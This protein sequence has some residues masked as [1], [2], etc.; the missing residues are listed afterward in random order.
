[1]SP[2]ALLPLELDVF[3]SRARGV[4]PPTRLDHYEADPAVLRSV[5]H[6]DFN[7]CRYCGFHSNKYQQAVRLGSLRDLDKLVTACIF[8]QS[9]VHL[10][11]VESARCG[12]LVWLP[13]LSQAKLHEFLRQLYIARISQ[14]P[15]AE[16]AR[17]LVSEL[18]ERS[19]RAKDHLS[20]S[21]PSR[22]AGQMV[23]NPDRERWRVELEPIRLMPLDRLIRHEAGLEFNQFPQILAYWRSKDGPYFHGRLGRTP[24]PLVERAIEE[25]WSF[26]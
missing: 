3:N 11:L 10:E 4:Y 26:S 15:V 19:H 1:M 5:F 18:R 22:L 9:C 23:S 8:C 16:R 24:T 17:T 12:L 13:E 2:D 7:R 20:T 21:D 14:G 25:A 6:R